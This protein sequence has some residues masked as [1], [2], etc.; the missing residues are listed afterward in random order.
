MYATEALRHRED[1][2]FTS[3]AESISTFNVIPV[4]IFARINI[5][6]NPYII[7]N[8]SPL[9]TTNDIEKSWG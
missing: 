9:A 1:L 8:G 5:S 7:G 2:S 6:V 4:L 3:V